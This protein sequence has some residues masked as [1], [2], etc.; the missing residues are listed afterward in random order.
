MSEA[1][2]VGDKIVV[3]PLRGSRYGVKV[4]NV[5]ECLNVVSG[6]QFRISDPSVLFSTHKCVRLGSSVKAIEFVS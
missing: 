6:R 3:T 1:V 5:Y 4:E 2:K